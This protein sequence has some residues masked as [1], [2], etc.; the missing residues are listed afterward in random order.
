MC[1][2]IEEIIFFL[3][4]ANSI[5]CCLDVQRM[6]RKWFSHVMNGDIPR[7]FYL[8]MIPG[9]PTNVFITGIGPVGLGIF[10]LFF[11]EYIAVG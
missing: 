9:T 4:L 2:Y 10:E 6:H 3:D 7:G 11:M 1:R 5:T 8:V